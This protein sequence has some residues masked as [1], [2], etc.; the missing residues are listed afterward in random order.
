MPNDSLSFI[1]RVNE[2]GAWTYLI[3]LVISCWAGTVKFLLDVKRGEKPSFINWLIETFV[4]GFVGFM[5]M[6]ACQ[7][8]Q[9]D[10]LLT[11]VIVGVAAHNGTRSL[12][13]LSNFIKK[14][15]VN[16]D[17]DQETIEIKTKSARKGEQN[18]S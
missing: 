5:F 15:T 6:L 11:G 7:Y 18:D 8:Y 2:Y 14:N 16:V 4:S 13:F 9:V 17:I 3:F 10:V 1:Q 12:Y